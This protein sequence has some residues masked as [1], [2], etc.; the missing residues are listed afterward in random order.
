L[1]MIRGAAQHFALAL[2]N[3]RLREK[4]T[5]RATRDNLTGLY[6]RHF[7]HEWLEQEL[8]RAQRRHRT[9]G[10]IML[11]VDHFKRVNDDFGH[12][13]GDMVLRELAGVIR[14]VARRSDV[15]CRQGGEEF[16]LLMPEVTLEGMLGKTEEPRQELARLDLAYEGR[17]LGSVTLS[18]GVAIYPH[19]ATTADALIRCPDEALYAAKKAGATGSSCTPHARP[20]SN[21]PEPAGSAALH[22]YA[23]AH[24][25]A[26]KNRTLRPQNAT[27]SGLNAPDHLSPRYAG[28]LCL[29]HFR[30]ISRA[31]CLRKRLATTMRRRR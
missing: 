10:V 23:T 18:A 16:L 27:T 22:P 24:T 13:A 11:D 7:M 28:C 2:A 17:P 4:L 21:R 9:I 30:E 1:N 31:I 29:P 15:A 14:R 12:P 26:S 6:N 5:E 8:H 19:H 3:L 20:V 25:V